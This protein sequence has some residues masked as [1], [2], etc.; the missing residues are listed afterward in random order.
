MEL[1]ASLLLR[2]MTMTLELLLVVI[3]HHDDSEREDD[4]RSES[5]KRPSN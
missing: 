4:A 1:K 2:R 5:A 3:D